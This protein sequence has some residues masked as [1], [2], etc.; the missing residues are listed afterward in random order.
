MKLGVEVEITESSSSISSVGIDVDEYSVEFSR[1]APYHS[2]I[3]Y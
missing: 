2:S 1:I 3:N